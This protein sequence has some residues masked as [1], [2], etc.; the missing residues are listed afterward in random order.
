VFL[1]IITNDVGWLGVGHLI[2]LAGSLATC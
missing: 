1:D 2:G